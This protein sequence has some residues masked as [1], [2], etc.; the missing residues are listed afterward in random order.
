M[1]CAGCG[2]GSTTIP[3]SATMGNIYD[4]RYA[5]PASELVWIRYE[6]PEH[7][8]AIKSPTGKLVDYPYFYGA[9]GAEFIIHRDDMAARPTVFVEIDRAVEPVDE[10]PLGSTVQVAPDPEGDQVEVQTPE[11]TTAPEP[12]AEAAPVDF[13]ELEGIGPAGA[14]KLNSAGITTFQQ[15]AGNSAAQLVG[16]LGSPMTNDKAQAVIEAAAARG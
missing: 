2:S 5:Y 9:R 8:H 10:T 7:T 14:Q 13:T 4:V 11:P 6:G 1:A 12:T 3:G 16:I 15:L